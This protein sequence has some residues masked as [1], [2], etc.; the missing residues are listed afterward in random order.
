MAKEHGKHGKKVRYAVVGAGNIAQVA[1]LPA[2]AHARENSELVAL[3]SGDAEKREELGKRYSIATL[4]GYDDLE[5]VLETARADAVYIC[6]PNTEHRDLAVRAADRGVHVLCEKP[7]ATSVEDCEAMGEACARNGVYLMVAYRLHFEAANLKAIE[8]ARSGELGEPRLFSSFFSH[9]VRSGDI[10]RDPEVGGG[11][12]YDLGVYCIN[13]VRHLFAAEPIEVSAQVVEKNGADD[14]T[15]VLLRFPDDRLAH[16]CVSN[17]VAGVSSYRIA[18]DRG[19]LR[20]EPA[21]EY[22]EGNTHYLTVDEKTKRNAF[23]KSD[24]FAPE[25][26]YFSQ[27]ILDQRVPEPSVEEGICDIRVVEAI[28]ASART[29]KPVKLPPYQRRERPSADQE[30]RKP[31]ISKPDTVNAPSPGIR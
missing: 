20:L 6:T 8:I 30:I 2:F 12:C 13:A 28:L 26:I 3:I 27:C 5:R 16:F 23:P 31:P 9:V 29:G 1:V 19:D 11:A 18:G 21:F 10:R 17:S 22:A 25:L 15:T 7:L 24:Q 4:G 14:T